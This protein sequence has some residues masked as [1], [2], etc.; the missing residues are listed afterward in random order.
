ML[1]TEKSQHWIPQVVYVI[2][3]GTRRGEHV[4]GVGLAK[5]PDIPL[6]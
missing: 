6:Q 4:F 1:M 3:I 2:F 5:K